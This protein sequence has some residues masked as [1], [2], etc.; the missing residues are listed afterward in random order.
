MA[1]GMEATETE[2]DLLEAAASGDFRVRL[3]AS[4]VNNFWWFAVFA[5][6]VVAVIAVII[7]VCL[8]CLF[9]C[10]LVHITHNIAEC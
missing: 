8:L 6:V 9:G 10:F 1:T 5:V 2:S 4:F 3:P 7:V